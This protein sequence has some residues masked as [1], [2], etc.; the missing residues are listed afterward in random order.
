MRPW[1]LVRAIKC[2]PKRKH[3]TALIRTPGTRIY[4]RLIAA[5][6]PEILTLYLAHTFD[7]ESLMAA[8]QIAETRETLISRVRSIHYQTR[9]E[10]P[11]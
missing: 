10:L 5:T 11:E 3:W 7:R 1:S 8:A 6:Y 2:I 9:K 4:R